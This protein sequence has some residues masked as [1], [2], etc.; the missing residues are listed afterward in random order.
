[1]AVCEIHLGAENALHRAVSF[2]AILPETA[3]PGPFAVLYLLHGQSDNHTTWTR[4]TSIERYVEGLPLIVVMPNGARGWYSDSHADPFAAYESYLL[5]DL[6]PFVDRTF[7]TRA[8]RAGRVIAGLSMGGFGAVKLALK[9]PELFCAAASHS[10]AFLAPEDW[11]SAGSSPEMGRIFGKGAKGGPDD[12]FALAERAVPSRLP[13]LRLDCGHE[14]YLLDRNR[15]FHRHLDIHGIPHEY[16]EH[17]GAHDWTYW[18]K[19]VRE[20]IVFFSQ[21]LGITERHRG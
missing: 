14:D 4:R 11:D 17:P 18:D 13:A 8:S 1:M 3:G 16:A 2:M 10:G 21:A 15:R 20:T 5:R 6:L 9:H 12:V 19:H 7:H